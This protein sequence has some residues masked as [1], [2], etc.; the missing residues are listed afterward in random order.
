[1]RDTRQLHPDLQEIIPKFLK[2]CRES[3]LEV[4]ITECYRTVKEQDDLYAKGRTTVGS[5]VT[6]CKGVDFSSPHQWGIAFDFCRNDKGLNAYYDK[7]NF[8]TKVGKIGE[9]LGLQ[10]GGDWKSF[11][12][13]PHLQLAKFFDSTETTAYIKKKY[14]TPDKFMKT[15][16]KSKVSE[17]WGNLSMTELTKKLKSYTSTS[18]STS[19]APNK[20]TVTAT[21]TVYKA[22]TAINLNKTPLYVSADAKTKSSTKTG[23]FYIYDD[24]VVNKRIKITTTV[25][26]CGKDRAVTGWINV[27]DIKNTNTTTINSNTT[28]VKYFP[29][30]TGKTVS[31]VS[32]LNSLKI[33]SNYAYRVKIAKAN[34]IAL[35]VGTATQNTKM[36]N[37]LKQSKLIKP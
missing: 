3:G 25:A 22:K 17:N 27:S 13:K 28:K 16:G 10:W 35:Y 34:K 6:N 9:T 26:N 12:D 8:F 20:T 11:V 7:D 4:K 31:I 29:K 21:T 23:T 2:K 14:G 19:T 1:M 18:T 30:Y 24:K 37:L 15:W 5:I 36:L 33:T 32:A